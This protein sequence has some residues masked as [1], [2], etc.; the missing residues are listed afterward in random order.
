MRQLSLQMKYPAGNLRVYASPEFKSELE[1]SLDQE[2]AIKSQL[3][4]TDR[5]VQLAVE[6]VLAE[7]R[8]RI[9]RIL[10]EEQR[11]KSVDML[12]APFTFTRET[13]E[14]VRREFAAARTRS[15]R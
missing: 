13:P 9:Q 6:R 10:T 8:A 15:P 11:S 2:T 1:Y 14:E 3:E 5:E 4:A 7:G 12:G